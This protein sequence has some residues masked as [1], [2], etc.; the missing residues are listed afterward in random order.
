MFILNKWSISHPAEIDP[1]SPGGDDNDGVHHSQPQ[2]FPWTL[3]QGLEEEGAQG[4]QEELEE[5][6]QGAQ[7]G[8]Q[9]RPQKVV[10]GSFSFAELGLFDMEGNEFLFLQL[11]YLYL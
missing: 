11:I 9:E 2:P 7:E 10:N 3:R 8:A 5:E 4:P 6:G 1:P